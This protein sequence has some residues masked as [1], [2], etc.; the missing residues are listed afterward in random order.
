MLRHL[1]PPVKTLHALQCCPSTQTGRAH[2]RCKAS[3]SAD[4]RCPTYRQGLLYT[5]KSLSGSLLVQPIALASLSRRPVTCLS[6]SV[7]LLC[8][9]RVPFVF[10]IAV[11]AW[12]QFLLI[13]FYKVNHSSDDILECRPLFPCHSVVWEFSCLAMPKHAAILSCQPQEVSAAQ[14]NI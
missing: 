4:T 6:Q 2:T 1:L 7:R 10:V 3:P 9:C 8:V 5:G 11:I 12:G 13:R 14:Q